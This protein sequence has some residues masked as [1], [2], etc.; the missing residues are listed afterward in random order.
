MKFYLSLINK[1]WSNLRVT[2]KV[3]VC[4]MMNSYLLVF[5][6]GFTCL[7]TIKVK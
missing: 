7:L 1:F 5:V 2:V 4:V 6:E 3:V